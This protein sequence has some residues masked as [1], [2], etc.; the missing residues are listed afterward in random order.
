MTFSLS[1]SQFLQVYAYRSPASDLFFVIWTSIKT[2]TLE[3]HLE[4][5]LQYYHKQLIETLQ[6]HLCD[7]RD[8]GYDKFLEEMRLEARVEISHA[9]LFALFVAHGVKGTE[10]TTPPDANYFL[11]TVTDKAKEKLYFLVAECERRGWM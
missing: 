10:L 3:K 6:L 7:I 2:E 4:E 11:N 8:F 1:S 9:L 5:I